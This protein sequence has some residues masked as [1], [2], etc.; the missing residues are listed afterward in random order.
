MMSDDA[1]PPSRVRSDH[2]PA[3]ERDETRFAPERSHGLKER[4][5]DGQR[6]RLLRI[7]QAYGATVDEI[8]AK[9]GLTAEEVER[10]IAHR[11]SRDAYRQRPR[12]DAEVGWSDEATARMI[13]E[14]PW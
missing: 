8:A 10:L 7:A 13:A 9:T 3:P 1:L 12:A 14:E 6:A 2:A 11:P 5:I 4:S